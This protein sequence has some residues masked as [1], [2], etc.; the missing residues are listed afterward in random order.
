MH[1]TTTWVSCNP[2]KLSKCLIKLTYRIDI[3]WEKHL[4]NNDQGGHKI[5]APSIIMLN[6]IELKYNC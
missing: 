4:G 5:P 6:F 1:V 2:A 3:R